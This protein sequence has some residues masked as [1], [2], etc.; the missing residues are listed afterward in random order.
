MEDLQPALTDLGIQVKK[1]AYYMWGGVDPALGTVDMWSVDVAD[2]S[3]ECDS[4]FWLKYAT[5]V[6]MY[7]IWSS[8]SQSSV[9]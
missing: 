9:K 6:R 4:S 5:I 1:P 8:K 7:G 2:V 3:S